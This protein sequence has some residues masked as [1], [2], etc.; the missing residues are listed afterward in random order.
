MSHVPTA[1]PMPRVER[2]RLGARRRW[3]P[4]PRIVRLDALPPD[5]RHA[6]LS[7]LAVARSTEKAAPDVETGAAESEGHGNDRPTD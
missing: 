5:Q 4:E 7:Y 2:G 1:T 3:G 6:I